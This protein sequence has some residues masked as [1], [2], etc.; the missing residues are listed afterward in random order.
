VAVTGSILFI[1]SGNTDEKFII[2]LAEKVISYNQD[3]AIEKVFVQTDKQFYQ[4][5]ERIWF[6]AYIGSTFHGDLRAIS[7]DLFIRVFDDFGN[8]IIWKRFPVTNNMAHGVITVPQSAEEGKY[9]FTAF[10]GWMKNME[11]EDVYHNDI[12]ICK[13]NQRHLLI[14]AKLNE[15][16]Y[17]SDG[18]I[19][20]D[21]SVRT[22]ELQPAGNAKYSYSVNCFDEVII[23]GKGETDSEGKGTISFKLPVNTRGKL[24]TLKLEA[25]YSGAT[26]GIVRLIQCANNNVDLG[27]YP[28]SG[29]IVA[30]LTNRIAFRATDSYGFPFDF[31]G[32]LYNDNNEPVCQIKS[33]YQGTGDFQFIPESEQYRVKITGPAGIDREFL[34]PR[35]NTDGLLLTYEGIKDNSIIITA[36]SG[37]PDEI[38]ETYWIGRMNNNI[39]W[40]MIINFKGNRK[41][42]IPLINFPPGILQISVFNRDKL[43]L[44]ERTIF[45]DKSKEHVVNVRTNKIK[46]GPREKVT[47]ILNAENTNQDTVRA[48]ISLSV[49]HK[50]LV[51]N[52][53]NLCSLLNSHPVNCNLSSE[54]ADLVSMADPQVLTGNIDLLMMVSRLKWI[55]YSDL[56]KDDII[57]E[58][59]YYK[60]D[61]LS[62]FVVDKKGNPVNKATIQFI[63]APNKQIYETATDEN[64]IFNILFADDIV[65]FNFLTLSIP[66]EVIRQKDQIIVDNIFSG[67]VLEYF[68]VNEENWD[69][70]KTKDLI[71]YNNPDIIYSGKYKKI[72]KD[73]IVI[74]QKKK[75]DRIHYAG[76]TN[77]LDIIKEMKTFTL[78]NNQIVFQGGINSLNFQQGALIV[79]DGVKTGTDIGVLQS[80]STSDIENINISTNVV[81]IHE[82]TGLNSQGIIEITTLTGKNKLEEARIKK[83]DLIDLSAYDFEFQSPDYEI[84]TDVRED[85]RT[86][87][88][89][90]PD[91]VI[92]PGLETIISFY[93]SDIKGEYVGRIE[94]LRNDGIPVSAEFRYK[95][96]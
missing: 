22:K 60:Q 15:N 33:S 54:S 83:D 51:N 14:D 59:P 37:N 82:Y 50:D 88:Y 68:T 71:K 45:I 81:D 17:N 29:N 56:L 58:Y 66:D 18:E 32:N 48:N 2:N 9:T 69:I 25:K 24:V 5:G 92:D 47:V 76:Y 94:G 36:A 19:G 70:R 63:H 65:D 90:N 3:Y 87:I 91:L 10:T 73:K 39:Y 12:V 79:I 27:F 40:G 4:P 72:S 11:A 42:E 78:I 95:V 6:K 52:P 53:Y 21:F 44:A 35:V 34:L 13:D 61:G 75:Y 41:V 16:N 80:I 46:Y 55:S 30:G 38:L 8:E 77:V 74:E 84:E 89:W 43:L 20:L 85:L 7:K 96:E 57:K 1:G 28:E 49:A 31:E 86:T 64:G 62:G 26:S 67:K 23:K 93:T